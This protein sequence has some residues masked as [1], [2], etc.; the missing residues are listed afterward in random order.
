MERD[1]L[2]AQLM[3]ALL[4]NP[5]IYA[6]NRYFIANDAIDCADALLQALALREEQEKTKQAQ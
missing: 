4:S 6:H 2:A 5:E 3:A 1:K